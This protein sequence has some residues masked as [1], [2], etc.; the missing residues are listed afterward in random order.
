MKVMKARR[1]P[2]EGAEGGSRIGRR[3]LLGGIGA[4]G[5]ATAATVFGFASP[6]SAVTYV[7]CCHLTCKPSGH[8]LKQCEAGTEYFYV[9]S[10]RESNGNTCKCCEY[11]SPGPHGCS[12]TRWSVGKCT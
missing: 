11:N 1:I 5:L 2:D 7:G 9:W 3:R 8:T 12:S 4:G 10:C 6:A